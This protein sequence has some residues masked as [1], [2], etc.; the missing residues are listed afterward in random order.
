MVRVF[1]LGI[2]MKTPGIFVNAERNGRSVP[3]GARAN[4]TSVGE[5]WGV[6]FMANRRLWEGDGLTQS[7]QETFDGRLA[8]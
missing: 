7:A 6:W 8:R 1:C 3:Q 4:G 2:C 5:S